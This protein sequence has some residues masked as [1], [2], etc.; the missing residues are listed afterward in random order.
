VVGSRHQIQKSQLIH[1]SNNF[2][3]NGL[4]SDKT[5]P[6]NQPHA[7]DTKTAEQQTRDRAKKKT[8]TQD[9]TP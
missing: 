8:R 7:N 3:T 9:A 6:T 1:K 5:M 2:R 4:F